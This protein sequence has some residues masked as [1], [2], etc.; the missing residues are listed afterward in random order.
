MKFSCNAHNGGVRDKKPVISLFLLFKKTL[1]FEHTPPLGACHGGG[2]EFNLLM[3]WNRDRKASY[4]EMASPVHV[5]LYKELDKLES[6][7]ITS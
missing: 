2:S 5:T 1:I 4:E 3:G 6:T 7:L